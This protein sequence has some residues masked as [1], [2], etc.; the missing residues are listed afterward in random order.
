MSACYKSPWFVPYK[1]RKDLKAQ[2]SQGCT[3]LARTKTQESHTASK[4]GLGMQKG[5][6]FIS[7][8]SFVSVRQSE[9]VYSVHDRFFHFCSGSWKQNLLLV[10]V[11][12]LHCAFCSVILWLLI[13]I[14]WRWACGTR[15]FIIKSKG[16]R[17]LWLDNEVNCLLLSWT[18]P[19]CVVVS[20][21]ST[22]CFNKCF[23]SQWWPWLVPMV[24]TDMINYVTCLSHE[25]MQFGIA[26]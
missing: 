20:L 4:N 22:L 24:W 16:G 21:L 26:C 2:I 10:S 12:L 25:Y 5:H 7:F 13:F 6:V 18:V 15:S 11:V 1:I 19:L 8:F 9:H 3:S 23:V 17:L 14:I